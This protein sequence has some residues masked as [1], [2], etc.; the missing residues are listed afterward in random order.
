MASGL[1]R[2][3]LL[4]VFL[5]PRPHKHINLRS[6]VSA[7]EKILFKFYFPQIKDLSVVLHVTWDSL[8]SYAIQKVSPARISFHLAQS[9]FP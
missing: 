9:L 6:E 8:P 7:I 1:I 4:Y 3:R 2:F 5:L